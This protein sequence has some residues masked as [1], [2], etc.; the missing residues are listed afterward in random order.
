M[1]SP[2]YYRTVERRIRRCPDEL[3]NRANKFSTQTLPE[4]NL[5]NDCDIQQCVSWAKNLLG[6]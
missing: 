1:E 4:K 5:E 6:N 2:V 3:V